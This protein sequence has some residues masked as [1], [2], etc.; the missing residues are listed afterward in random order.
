MKRFL[1]KILISAL[2][3]LVLYPVDFVY[4]QLTMH[5]NDSDVESWY[6]LMHGKIYSDVVIMG[7]SHASDH[8][9]P[10]VIDSI[11][12]TNSYNLGQVVKI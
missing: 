1:V 11:L 9:N 6:D 10:T 2:P 12:I 5:S 8:Y 7:N 4:S 3:F